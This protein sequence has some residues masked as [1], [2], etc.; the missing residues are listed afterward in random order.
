MVIVHVYEN[1]THRPSK[2]GL[3]T[4]GGLGGSRILATLTD[5]FRDCFVDEQD[6]HDEDGQPIT[7]GKITHLTLI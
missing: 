4:F 6:A 5:A 2:S 1:N 7:A 3:L